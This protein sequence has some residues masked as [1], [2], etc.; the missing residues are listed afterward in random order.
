MALVPRKVG[1]GDSH[2]T[3]LAIILYLSQAP[4]VGRSRLHVVLCVMKCVL[5]QQMM[6]YPVTHQ[7]PHA[8]PLLSVAAV[9]LA[10]AQGAAGVVAGLA[11]TVLWLNCW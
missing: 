6:S 8:H 1:V 2:C 4:S 11:G 3:E 5:P 10:L 7:N 9:E